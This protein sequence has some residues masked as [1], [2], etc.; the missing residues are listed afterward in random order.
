MTSVRAKVAPASVPSRTEFLVLKMGGVTDLAEVLDV[1]KSQPSRWRTGAESPSPEKERA[2][3]D[4]DH[5]V[6]RAELLWG[7][8]DVAH[9]WLFS[10]NAYLGGARPVDVVRLRGSA[11]VIEALD[12][13]M[14]GAYA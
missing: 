7:D 6:A 8:A 9:D 13:A 12:E 3:L 4:L 5:V 1:S 2:L 11:E 14:A 10:S